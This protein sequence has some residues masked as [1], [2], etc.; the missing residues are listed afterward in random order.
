MPKE[1][2][3]MQTILSDAASMLVTLLT[4]SSED[5]NEEMKLNVTCKFKEAAG[6][7]AKIYKV[8]CC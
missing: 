6:V 1:G 8:E 2:L 5:V 4:A 7:G 3:T